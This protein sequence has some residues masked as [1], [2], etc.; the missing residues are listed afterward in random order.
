MRG[1]RKFCQRGPTFDNVYFIYL[2]LF[3]FY[4]DEGMNDPNTTIS[5]SSSAG[6]QNA[7]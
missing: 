7:I 2:L 1:S 5:E 4:F 6:Q 3:R